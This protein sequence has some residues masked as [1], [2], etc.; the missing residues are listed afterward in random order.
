MEKTLSP[1]EMYDK[2]NTVKVT[3]KL[4]LNTDKDILD[5]LDKSGNK[6]GTIK[7]LI[8]EDMARINS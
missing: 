6:Q 5:Y 8:R 2:N 4:N 3:I 1:K 7:R